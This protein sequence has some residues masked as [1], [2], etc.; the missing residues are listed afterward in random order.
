MTHGVDLVAYNALKHFGR[1]V[2]PFAIKITTPF[3]D[4]VPLNSC[5]IS[6]TMVRLIGDYE[7]KAESD[8]LFPNQADFFRAYSEN[9]DRDFIMTT[10]T[11]SGKSLCFLAWVFDQLL[12][13]ENAT[14]LL[15]F[16]TQAL[17]WS[18]AGRLADLSEKESLVCRDI[19]DLAYS[20]VIDVASGQIPW[21]IWQGTG[22]GE[23]PNLA[24]KE[25]EKSE[26]FKNARIRVATL[27]KAHFSLIGQ[28]KD[29]LENMVCMVL[30]E[31]HMYDG[32]FG[33]NVH[34]FLK[35]VFLSM[36]ILGK[37]RPK[38]FLASATL[39][40][41]ESFARTL[42]SA[43][44]AQEVMHIGETSKQQVEQIR[45]KDLPG[46][47]KKPNSEGLLKVV[48]LLDGQIKITG[49]SGRK[50]SV[51]IES[52]LED[53]T[54]LGSDVNAI[55]F[56]QSKFDGKRLA[57]RLSRTSNGHNAVVYDADLPPKERRMIEKRMNDQ[58]THGT[59][60]IGT[61]ALELGVDIENL[62]VC[63]M[64]ELPPRQTEMLQRM[65]RIGR[66]V[67][68][69][70][71][72]IAKL[73]AKPR[74]LGI[75][76]DPVAAFQFKGSIPALIPVHLEMIKWKHM[77]I[78]HHEW[79]DDL[80]G[81]RAQ[82]FSRSMKHHFGE[83]RSQKDL[84]ELFND[85][86]GS[87]VNTDDAFWIYKGFRATVSEGKI[88]LK[89]GNTEV[90]RIDAIAIY[91]DAHP[92]AVYLGHYQKLYRVV[93]YKGKW[94][95]A[96]WEHVDSEYLLGKWMLAVSSIEVEEI[97]E[98]ITTRG[99]WDDNF[100]FYQAMIDLPE[101][102]DR[103]G[104]GTLEYGI[105]DYM[106]KWTGY[107]QIDLTSN[108]TTKV[109]LEEVTERF[110][111]AMEVGDKFPFLFPFT[112]RTLGWE[113]DFGKIDV[114]DFDEEALEALGHLAG[115]LLRYFLAEAVESRAEDLITELDLANHRLT[116]LDNN[117]GGNGMSE[118]LLSE[119]RMTRALTKCQNL[120]SKFN[121]ENNRKN[122]DK[123]V[124]DLCGTDLSIPP[125]E[126]LNVINQLQVHWAR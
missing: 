95:K 100:S 59:L 117:P 116:T 107:T 16:P 118:S 43:E 98:R 62:D 55:Y 12:R 122:F 46:L 82:A 11:G 24:M 44:E 20:G 63:L 83:F 67:N 120:L 92:E 27:D 10:A 2:Y 68:H 74:D 22:P 37:P 106:R 54:S 102:V 94:K 112:Y 17:M 4:R 70:G 79:K 111:L 15:C 48:I 75:L 1:A 25:H 21:T 45:L 97:P 13:D 126:I 108:R 86:Y 73:S 78:A 49:N 19:K 66:R 31:A 47:L 76:E 104:K 23:N 39:S 91:R 90:A 85:R 88:P 6:E 125:E 30:D 29:F 56:T 32:V 50:R 36:D 34:Y 101:H 57:D 72:V 80:Y 103:P 81:G 38:V 58:D 28:H 18:Q 114:G 14:S 109:T 84:T 77:L 5:G 42:I 87:L 119:G 26:E 51:K 35:R 110:K 8:G 7:P 61:S 89:E 64:D 105:W 9:G 52:F 69:T 33:A 3:P 115:D 124:A 40:S 41:A 60:I 113:W 96:E 65:G 53:G 93:D 99:S 121:G 71:L 123:Y